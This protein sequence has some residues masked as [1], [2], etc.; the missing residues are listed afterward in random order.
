MEDQ[1]L[2]LLRYVYFSYLYSLEENLF[3]SFITTWN[4]QK[5][6]YLNHFVP[7][8]HFIVT[9]KTILHSAVNC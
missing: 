6:F 2:V 8:L 4:G 9:L 5:E 3:I 1:I 7:P